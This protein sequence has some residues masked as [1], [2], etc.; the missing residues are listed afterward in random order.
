MKAAAW[1]RPLHQPPFAQGPPALILAF[2][3]A[4][5]LHLWGQV[6]DCLVLTGVNASD[7]RTFTWTRLR[8]VKH[9]CNRHQE[10]HLALSGSQGL[11]PAPSQLFPVRTRAGRGSL[12]SRPSRSHWTLSGCYN[13]ASK[14]SITLI[15]SHVWAAG[16]TSPAWEERG[17]LNSVICKCKSMAM[18][19]LTAKK[20]PGKCLP[21]T[22]QSRSRQ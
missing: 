22:A 21:P 3:S 15:G 13:K 16:V 17:V 6:V 20:C 7:V 19:A 10:E 8:H 12:C 9:S 11:R 14:H 18:I 4:F 1:R 2:L 5:L